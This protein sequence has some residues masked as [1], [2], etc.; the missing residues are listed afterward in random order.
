[1]GS[2]SDLMHFRVIADN[3]MRLLIAPSQVNFKNG[4]PNRRSFFS[5]KGAAFS[6]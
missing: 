1:M 6:F 4:K 2:Q 5:N 3:Y